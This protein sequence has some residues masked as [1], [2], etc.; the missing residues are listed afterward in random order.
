M[1]GC[2]MFWSEQLSLRRLQGV[3]ATTRLDI[4]P[5]RIVEI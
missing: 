4:R 2:E 1:I 3:R 5:A